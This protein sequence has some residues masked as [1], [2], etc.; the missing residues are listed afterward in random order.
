MGATHVARRAARPQRRGVPVQ[1]RHHPVQPGGNFS[2][3]ESGLS[4]RQGIAL[5]RAAQGVSLVV[6]HDGVARMQCRHGIGHRIQKGRRE[7]AAGRHL[8][9]EVAGRHA[10]HAHDPIHHLAGAAQCQGAIHLPHHRH[11]VAIQAGRVGGIQ[12][13]FA[14]RGA[15]AL[16]QGGEVDEGQAD[17]AAQLEHRVRANEYGGDM[18]LHRGRPG[19]ALEQRG[20]CGLFA[21]DQGN[22]FWTDQPAPAR[23]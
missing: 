23:V 8:V 18:R 16:G 3:V 13:Q 19:Q 1:Q 9:E 21:R 12:R 15:F 14:P 7:F 4:C 5:G 6:W 10:G 20:G 11:D 2:G 22:S 17:R